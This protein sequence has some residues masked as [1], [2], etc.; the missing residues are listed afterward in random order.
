MEKT[1]PVAPTPAA[2]NYV[3]APLEIAAPVPVVSPLLSDSQY[4]SQD[5]FDQYSYGYSVSNSV[6]QEIK[7]DDSVI[8][9]APV[10]EVGAT[11][12]PVHIV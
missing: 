8:R 2:V 5:D 6:K 1:A 3:Q 9:N 10:F 11:N 4:H 12:L 7:T